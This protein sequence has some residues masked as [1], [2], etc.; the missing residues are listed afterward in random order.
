MEWIPAA[1]EIFDLTTQLAKD[2]RSSR[3]IDRVTVT[4]GYSE[5]LQLEPHN[6]QYR[7][8]LRQA[9]TDLTTAGTNLRVRIAARIKT[10]ASQI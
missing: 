2:T 4:R 8:K 6:L 10:L 1:A 7:D 9:L 3:L 5:L